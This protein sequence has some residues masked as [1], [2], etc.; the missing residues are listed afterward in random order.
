MVSE[1]SWYFLGLNCHIFLFYW[2]PSLSPLPK[3]FFFLSGSL[4]LVEFTISASLLHLREKRESIRL[5]EPLTK[6]RHSSRQDRRKFRRD[7]P[8]KLRRHNRPYPDRSDPPCPRSDPSSTAAS[9]VVVDWVR[10]PRSFL[11]RWLRRSWSWRRTTET[12][13]DVDGRGEAEDEDGD[14]RSFAKVSFLPN[15]GDERWRWRGKAKD[16]DRDDQS[17]AKLSFLI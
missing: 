12:R 10:V 7:R 8:R 9:V 4:G 5:S 6:N 11:R 2:W 16:E 17:F 15:D 13:G 14:D 3:Y 1:Q